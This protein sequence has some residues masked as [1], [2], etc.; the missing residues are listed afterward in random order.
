VAATSEQDALRLPWAGEFTPGQ[1]GER[2]LE[3]ALNLV[4]ANSGDSDRVVEA[5]RQRWFTGAAQARSDP[6]ERLRQQR[7]RA[8]NVVNGMQNYGLVSRAYTLTDVGAE[9]R[10]E[11]DS[12]ERAEQFVG[13]ILKHC[14][15]L[16]LVDLVR[17]LRQRGIR[18]NN[19]EVRAELRRRGYTV[20]VND[21]NPGKMRQWLATSG[22]FDDSWN[23]DEARVAQITG[24]SL[25]AIGEWQTLSKV[26]RAFLGVIRRLSE[27]RGKTPVPSPE[28]LDFVRQEHGL[29]YDEGQVRKV[30]LSLDK[31]GWI[32]HTVKQGGRGGKG[33]EIAATDKLTEV[34]FELL[35][36]FKPG[37]LPADVRAAMTMPLDTVYRNLRSD[38]THTKGIA[39]EVL[40][41]KLASDLGLI[42]LRLRV[43]GIRTGGAEVDLVAEAA[44]LHFSRWLFQCKNTRSVDIGVLA[45]EVGMATLLQAQVIVIATT[46]AFTGPVFTYADRVS[47]TTPF[48]VILVTA[49]ILEAYRSGGALALRQCFRENAR[50]AMQL[51]R[52]QVMDTLDELSEDES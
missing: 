49:K 8:R 14:R 28:F 44:H 5:I 51:K 25:A 46:G 21:S 18:I 41:A 45:K 22:V 35:V 2:A 15:G 43:R 9:L 11:P 19:D 38:N 17:D 47:E 13:Y 30:Y 40:S 3:E 16:E 32:E 34:D 36:G 48:Q 52:P 12:D 27:T 31:M 23:L 39:L 50:E 24:T 42:P 26:E 20:T 7:T 37:D 1:L 29:I 4:E 10:S 6:A 33:G